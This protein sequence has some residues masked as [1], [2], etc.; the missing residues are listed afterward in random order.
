MSAVL[1]LALRIALT[2][3]LYAFLAWALW[4]LWQ[5][6]RVR[7]RLLAAPAVPIPPIELLDLQSGQAHRFTQPQLSLG[8][9][10]ACELPLEDSTVSARH[11]RLA[12]QHEQWWLHDLDSRNGTFLNHGRL[13]APAALAHGDELRLG[14]LRFEVRLGGEQGDETDTLI[15]AYN[16]GNPSVQA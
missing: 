2:L 4:V 3:A 6:L 16:G 10:P 11:A 15:P 5:D 8:R 7:D 9:D 14:R 12:Y 1:A 13:T